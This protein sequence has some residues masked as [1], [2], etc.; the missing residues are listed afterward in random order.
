MLLADENKR[1]PGSNMTLC[2]VKD[3]RFIELV[4]GKLHDNRTGKTYLSSRDYLRI[5]HC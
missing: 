1:S 5:T 3:A 4:D 2:V